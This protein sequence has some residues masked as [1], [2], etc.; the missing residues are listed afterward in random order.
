MTVPQKVRIQ[1]VMRKKFV[2]NP[3]SAIKFEVPPIDD[4]KLQLQE[5]TAHQY[6]IGQGEGTGGGLLRW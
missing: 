5:V 2:V 6:A 3:F 4:V 1:K